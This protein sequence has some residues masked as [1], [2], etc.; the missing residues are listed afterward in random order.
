M[1][2]KSIAARLG[3]AAMALTL[4]TTSLTSGTLAKYT[5]EG[6]FSATA[7]VARWN[8]KVTVTENGTTHDALST[9][10]FSLDM[11][12]LK[13]TVNA[14]TLLAGRIAPGTEGSIPIVI[15]MSGGDAAKSTEVKTDYAVYAYMDAASADAPPNLEF[16][17]NANFQTTTTIKGATLPGEVPPYDKMTKISSGSI[18]VGSTTAK[19]VT[20][21]WRWLYENASEDSSSAVSRDDKDNTAGKGRIDGVDPIKYHFVVV[22]TQANPVTSSSST[23]GS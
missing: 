23:S 4:V 8:P 6:S 14:N 19:E 2:K 7:L 21:Y 22:L 9:S 1:K 13:K 16:S 11:A 3:V 20:L 5:A 15:D 17:N 18:D 10:S 12:A